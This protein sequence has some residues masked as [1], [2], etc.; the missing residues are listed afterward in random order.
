[1]TGEGGVV[2]N[3]SSLGKH[4]HDRCGKKCNPLSIG[5]R[6]LVGVQ[7]V[8]VYPIRGQTIV[9]HAPKATDFV[10]FVPGKQSA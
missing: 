4:D 8:R 6:S 3:A 1:M 5:A 2:V 10:T 9:A 7:D